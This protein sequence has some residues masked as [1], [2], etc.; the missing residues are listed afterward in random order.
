MPESITITVDDTTEDVTLFVAAGGGVDSVFG[1]AGSVVAV[2]GDYDTD[3]VTEATN[4]YYTE[5]RVS[6]NT[7]V[8]ANTAKTG[9]TA[10]QATDITTNNA[11]VTNATHTGDATGATAL[12][13]ATV[14]SNVGSFTTA[15]VTVNA[16]G[17]VTAVSNGAG[18]GDYAD[19]GEAG[20][21]DRTLG[22]TDAFSLGLLTNNLER[23]QIEADGKVAVVNTQSASNAE[24]TGLKVTPTINQS[25]TAAYNGIKVDATETATGDGSTGDGNNLLNLAVGGVSKMKVD[26]AGLLYTESI[27]IPATTTTAPP[28]INLRTGDGSG[29]GFCSPSNGNIRFVL[30]GSQRWFMDLTAFGSGGTRGGK[31]WRD[32]ASTTQPF[33]YPNGDT[34]T[35]MG[36]AGADEISI[37]TGGV[38][39]IKVKSNQTLNFSST[40]AYADEA[41]AVTAGLATGDIYQTT[42]TAASPLNV[43]GILMI[44]Q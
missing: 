38:E 7:D 16:K 20:G 17:L 23:V 39:A 19:G 24:E 36:S 1:R 32:G 4:L 8:A 22:N 44:K 43:A 41:A 42:G 31:L 26:N 15:N 13:L 5:A 29:T 12:T 6:A 27:G 28:T 35:G 21:A 9:I 14:N 3:E 18:G 11:K 34:N 10:Q 33:V 30:S 25:G 2:A 40:P 37:I